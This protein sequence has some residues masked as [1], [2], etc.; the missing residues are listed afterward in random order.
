MTGARVNKMKIAYVTD[1]IYPFTI[2]GSEIRNYEI[3]KRLVK[4]GHEVHIYG[5]KLWKGPS[6]K[7]QEGIILHGLY[8]FPRGLYGKNGKRLLWGPFLLS[9]RILR[10][11][12]HENYDLIDNMAF[13]FFNCYATKMASIFKNIPLIFTWHQY[14]GDY[15]KIYFPRACPKPSK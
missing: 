10:D 4:K 14:F 6:V 3:A 13:D 5:A 7:N 8:P 2:G 1:A 11:L 15:L 12:L 9:L